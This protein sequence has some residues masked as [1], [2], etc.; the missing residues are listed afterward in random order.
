MKKYTA[1]VK[2]SM[3]KNQLGDIIFKGQYREKKSANPLFPKIVDRMAKKLLVEFDEKNE[4]YLVTLAKGMDV[5]F[6]KESFESMYDLIEV[7]E[8]EHSFEQSLE[9][10]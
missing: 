6:S 8:I 3:T 1:T 7:E 4:K 5:S 9:D 2:G 10:E